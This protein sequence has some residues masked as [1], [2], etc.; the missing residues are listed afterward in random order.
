MRL[1]ANF[2]A[3]C[4][5]YMKKYHLFGKPTVLCTACMASGCNITSVPNTSNHKMETK[6]CLAH[7]PD[8]SLPATSPRQMPL[9]V[10]TTRVRR[11]AVAYD[12]SLEYTFLPEGLTP[13]PLAQQLEFKLPSSFFL[14]L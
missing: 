7:L 3:N 14:T 2:T 12:Q 6:T 10:P 5:E 11:N 9:R 4:R 1:C 13:H 8:T